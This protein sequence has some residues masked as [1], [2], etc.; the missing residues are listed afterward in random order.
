MAGEDPIVIP[1]EVQE[2]QGARA[3]IQGLNQQI[4][5]LRSQILALAQAGN[6]Q[7]ALGSAKQVQQLQALQR[8]LAPIANSNQQIIRTSPPAAA[9]VQQV[10][11][12]SG[13]SA[14]LLAALE[15]RLLAVAAAFEGFRAFKEFVA[16][17]F[18]F[19]RTVQG[20]TLGIATLITAQSNLR[21]SDGR[22]LEGTEALAAAQALS[23]EQ[24]RQL[25]IAG[26]QTAA[27]T[28]ELINAFN[29]GIASGLRYGLTLDQI[30]TITI[31]ISQAATALQLPMNQLNEEI[32]D[33]V[34]G[35]ISARNTRIA[36]ALGISNED[37]RKARETGQL[38]NFI[39]DRLKAFNVAGKE[40]ALT[41]DGV[42][43]N[44]REA[45]QTFAGDATKPLFES[46]RKNAQRALEGVFDL[47]TAQVSDKFKTILDVATGL[48][49]R[50]GDVLAR[51]LDAGVESAEKFN[52]WLKENEAEIHAIADAFGTAA[53]ALGSLIVDTIRLI[54][55]IADA[56]VESGFLRT[57]LVGAGLGVAAIHAGFQN[58]IGAIG[59]VGTLLATVVLLPLAGVSLIVGKIVGIFDK[60][61][62][63]A[64]VDLGR[65]EAQFVGEAI[66]GIIS[67][68]K[69]LIQGGDALDKYME[70]I[71]TLDAMQ[72]QAEG[73][74]RARDELRSTTAA[75]R[76]EEARQEAS[77]RDSLTKRLITRKQYD[78]QLRQIQL[79]ATK[80]ELGATVD[81]FRNSKDQSLRQRLAADVER[82]QQRRETLERGVV[83]EERT[84]GETDK[85]RRERLRLLNQEADDA[86]RNTKVLA[87]RLKSERQAAFDDEMAQAKNQFD[88]REQ[89]QVTLFEDL[90]KIQFQSLEKQ[91]DVER[92]RLAGLGDDP[93][94][95]ADRQKALD[96]IRD[97]TEEQFKI[98][99]DT[100]AKIAQA[101]REALDVRKRLDEAGVRDTIT[102]LRAQGQETKATALELENEYR[103]QLAALAKRTDDAAR[104][105]EAQI[106]RI[107]DTRVLKAQ[108]TE[109]DRSVSD[110]LGNL[111]TREQEITALRQT[112][113]ISE[114][115]ARREILD[116]YKQTIASLDEFIPRL[117]VIAD[118]T[119][120]RD[121]LERVKALQA[122]YQELKI[123]VGQVDENI[124]KLQAGVRDASEA[125]LGQLFDEMAD[126]AHRFSD[127][128]SDAATSV[129]AAI[130][131]IASQM[132]ATLIIERSLGFLSRLFGGAGPA[133][134]GA[135]INLGDII[136]DGQAEGGL[137]SFPGRP[138]NRDTFLVPMAN[139]E[140]VQSAPATSY[141]GVDAM[142]ILNRRGVERS[143]LRSIL[144]LGTSSGSVASLR[145]MRGPARGYAEGGL[146]DQPPLAGFS[147]GGFF[148]VLVE[149]TEDYVV[150]VL[151]SK[152]GVEAQLKNL[153]NNRNGANAALGIP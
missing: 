131:R 143:L 110:S 113:S 51:A 108:F 133:N 151:G 92:K 116:L 127:A 109:L 149:H 44:I 129:V 87:D 24:V 48:F 56:A 147:A 39:I 14:Q 47:D 95:E 54:G 115:E 58:L 62:G 55:F 88:S 69:G 117:V 63:D 52:D 29:Q 22:L 61:L 150:R 91:K 9:G 126:G 125:G 96:R 135:S 64:F 12:A 67:Y 41:F 43:S 82:L 37:I 152:G 118:K 74:R 30:R 138:T 15:R 6:T 89:Q 32:R 102:I 98:V 101:H 8:S 19:N 65:K 4:A 2:Q 34:A 57:T 90:E 72:A 18:D 86:V 36:T 104:Q 68:E 53:G 46:F 121:S 122:R 21:T 93:A 148:R 5:Q 16:T 40:V 153:K 20:A 50:M 25:R 111:Q 1:V 7:G 80:R 13:T 120:D 139:K 132:L 112:G 31:G 71:R 49:S 77:L 10:G 23:A 81:A 107:I 124:R 75:I 137:V 99:A 78:E 130:R 105:Q 76:S 33:L 11:N 103:D 140:F 141:Y 114:R 66:K 119:G 17:G 85:E 59:V 42:T 123:S 84:P 142:E 94:Q 79:D 45:V 100:D 145:S 38:A 83:L 35:N 3:V 26:I 136:D 146:V 28:Q 97:L 134:Q 60:D 144:R 128:W 27:T 73:S 70:K 106:R